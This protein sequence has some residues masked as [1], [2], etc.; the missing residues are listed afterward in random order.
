MKSYFLSC[1]LNTLNTLISENF[2]K[3]S[4][5][6]LNLTQTFKLQGVDMPS[7]PWKETMWMVTIGSFLSWCDIKLEISGLWATPKY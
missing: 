3:S 1:S 5:Q 7:I 4:I 6:K 2:K